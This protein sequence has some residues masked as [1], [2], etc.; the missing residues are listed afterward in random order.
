MNPRGMAIVTGNGKQG[1]STHNNLIVRSRNVDGMNVWAFTTQANFSQPSY[2]SYDSNFVYQ[3]SAPTFSA[4]GSVPSQN[5]ATYNN[6]IWDA[7]ASGTNTNNAG[8]S[9]PNPLTAAAVYAALG[10]GDKTTCGG[11]M[12]E[13]PEGGW[14][15]KI[16][17][18]LWQGYGR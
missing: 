2:M 8:V 16:R 11:Q 4:D 10:C 18:M 13:S 3:W 17:A 7:A 14:A 6:N 9:L 12:V 5:F 15:P 1:S